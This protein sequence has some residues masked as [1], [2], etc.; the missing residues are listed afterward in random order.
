VNF[1]TRALILLAH[2]T[3]GWALCF[4][5]IGIAMA[6]LQFDVALMVHAVAAPIFFWAVS[7]VYFGYFGFTSPLQTAIAFTGFVIVADFLVVGMLILRS[8]DMF[9]S[10]LGTWIPFALIFTSTWLTGLANTGKGGESASALAAQRRLIPRPSIGP[11]RD[12]PCR[13]G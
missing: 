6:T 3:V 1:S 13:S 10:P 9:A 5:T 8:L 12:R 7:T 4:A 2:A 11:A